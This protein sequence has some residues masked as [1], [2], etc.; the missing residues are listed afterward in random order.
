MKFRIKILLLILLTLICVIGTFLFDPVPQNPSFHKF[1]DRNE[2]LG[3]PNTLNVLSNEPFIAIGI[4]GL[5]SLKKSAIIQSV[6]IIYYLLFTGIILIGVGSGWYHLS[7]DNNS[8]V[9]DRIPMTIVF[10]AFLS[11]VVAEFIDANAGVCL[12]FPLIVTG[13]ASVLYWNY[14][15]SIGRGDLRL[16][17]LV[18][19]YPMVVIPAILLLFSSPGVRSPCFRA[20]LS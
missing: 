15:E 20:T 3:I 11:A 17:G 13:I 14:T 19:F 1:S 10:M 4:I 8:L 6:S 18:Q 2:I 7:P 16:Y 12:I 9:Y 5:L